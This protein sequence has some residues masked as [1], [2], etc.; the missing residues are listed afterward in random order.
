MS[1]LVIE[2]V[3]LHWIGEFDSCN[4]LCAHGDVRVVLDGGEIYRENEVTVSAGALYLLRTL[5][6]DHALGEPDFL[7]P[8][9]A[10]VMLVHEE[11]LVNISSCN[12]GGDWAVSHSDSGVAL[13]FPGGH[14]LRVTDSEWRR[15]VCAFSS[16]VRAFYFA[17]AKTPG[18]D[19]VEWHAA[20]CAEWDRLHIAAGGK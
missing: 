18:G 14:R 7:F 10:H 8:H 12:H 9:C 15:A 11:E 19:D 5:E 6:Q 16:R 3:E 2:P 1:R 20:F 13:V 4:D 17:T